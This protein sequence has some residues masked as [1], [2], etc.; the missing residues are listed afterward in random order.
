MRVGAQGSSPTPL[1][2]KPRA[3]SCPRLSVQAVCLPCLRATKPVIRHERRISVPTSFQHIHDT[4]DTSYV[5]IASCVFRRL[6]KQQIHF[7]NYKRKLFC[8]AAVCI[9]IIFEQFSLLFQ[10]GGAAGIRWIF[11]S[12]II[13][14]IIGRGFKIIR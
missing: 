5:Q 9:H 10:F 14:I 11:C 1:E 3:A 8:F 4:T 7:V 6:F 13:S 2:G 12:F